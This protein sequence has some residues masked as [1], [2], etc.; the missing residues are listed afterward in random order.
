[1]CIGTWKTDAFPSSTSL[2]GIPKRYSAPP[3]VASEEKGKSNKC[4][5]VKKLKIN[6][7]CHQ[8]YPWCLHDRTGKDEYRACVS[9]GQTKSD[10]GKK[11]SVESLSAPPS[12]AGKDASSGKKPRLW[13]LLFSLLHMGASRSRTTSLKCILKFDSQSL[14]KTYL[15]F[16]VDTE[17]PWYALEDGEHWSAEGSQL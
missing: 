12:R 4:L 13:M 5:G 3:R 14:K 16:V 15:I 10:Q 8:V 1:M 2:G 6:L 9:K 11:A 7:W 17:W